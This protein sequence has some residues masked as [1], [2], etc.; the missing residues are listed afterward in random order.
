MGAGKMAGGLFRLCFRFGA[1]VIPLF[2][3]IGCSV[4]DQPEKPAAFAEAAITAIEAPVQVARP[5]TAATE[6]ARGE[7]VTLQVNDT[8]TANEPGRGLFRIDDRVA[9]DLFRGSEFRL[10]GI[11]PQAGDTLFVELEQIKGHIRV[12]VNDN[13]KAKVRL[14]TSIATIT[15]LRPGTDFVI[16]HNPVA[17]SCIVALKG[18]V[19]VVGQGKVVTIKGGEATYVLKDKQPFDP[20]CALPNEINT[21]I[22]QKIGTEEIPPISKLVAA[23]KPEPCSAATQSAAA[24]NQAPTAA[25]LPSAERMVKIEPGVYSVGAATPN[26]HQAPA[27]EITLEGYWIDLYEVTNAQYQ[28]FIDQTGHASPANWPGE[29]DRPVAGITWD[30]ANAYCTWARKRLPSEAEWEVAAR[31][32]GP[33]PP[34]Y[35]WGSDNQAGGKVYDLPLD[36][37][38]AVGAHSFNQSAF[39]VFDMAGNVWEWVGEPYAPAAEYSKILRGGRYGLLKDMAYREQT[40]AN[41]ARFVPYAGFRCAADQVEGN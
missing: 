12:Q 23:W 4:F 31:G 28:V 26:E 22:N 30:D 18:E 7:T 41:N 11:T 2:F 10:T 13:A 38:Y 15:T 40:E 19:E 3:L 35:P 5:E 32:P 24:A 14:V 29:A 17:V 33:N 27:Q 1:I 25:P 20:I 8:M 39:G 9:V 34:T 37:P 21:W 36:A 6:V 16:C